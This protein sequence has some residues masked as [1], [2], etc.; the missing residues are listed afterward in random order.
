VGA[1]WVRLSK[2]PYVDNPQGIQSMKTI[3]LPYP[4]DYADLKSYMDAVK[5]VRN[6]WNSLH[7]KSEFKS[8]A[9]LWAWVQSNG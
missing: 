1:D 2:N 3:V 4:K 9:Q 5:P 7:A 8:P 6:E